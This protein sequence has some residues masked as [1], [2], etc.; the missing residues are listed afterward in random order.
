MTEPI[1]AVPMTPAEYE[2]WKAKKGTATGPADGTGVHVTLVLDRSGSMESIRSDVV[3][4]FNSFLDDQKAVPGDCVLTMVQFDSGGID[5][6]RRAE[7]I[8]QVHPMEQGDFV[9]RAMTPLYDAVGRTLAEAEA[10]QDG[11]KNLVVIVTDGLENASVEWTRQRVRE[12]IQRLE[13]Q[14]WTFVYLGANQD[15][16]AEGAGI[17]VSLDNAS[18]YVADSAGVA[19]TWGNVSSSTRRYRGQVA[20]GTAVSGFF[21]DNRQAEE[22]AKR[23][24]KTSKRT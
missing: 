18:G 19:A 22:D 8:A 1:I 15:A 17:G 23:R 24:G 14:G 2:E 9:P 21:T 6:L 7:P 5:T 10:R 11:R 12:A 13:A 4:G 3:G 16:Y 20:S